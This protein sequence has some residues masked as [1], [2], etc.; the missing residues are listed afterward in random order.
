MISQAAVAKKASTG[1]WNELDR[2]TKGAW[3][4]HHHLS[5]RAW[6]CTLVS[7]QAAILE[8]GEVVSEGDITKGTALPANMDRDP[9]EEDMENSVNIL[10]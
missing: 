7:H 4:H 2:W 8:G 1:E 9:N 10:K 6:G 5:G 3:N